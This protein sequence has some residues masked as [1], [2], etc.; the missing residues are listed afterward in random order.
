MIIQRFLKKNISNQNYICY[1]A[2][3]LKRQKLSISDDKQKPQC[4]NTGVF[5]SILAWWLK[6]QADY[7]LFITVQPF[8]NEMAN[9]TCHNSDYQRQKYIHIEHLPS[10]PVQEAVTYLSYHIF[11]HYSTFFYSINLYSIIICTLHFF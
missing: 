4:W 2:N 10:A 5:Y 11:H 3:R 6:P 9:D 1:N 7:Q 8:A